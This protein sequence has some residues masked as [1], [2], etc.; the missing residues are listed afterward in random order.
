MDWIMEVSDD[1]GVLQSDMCVHYSELV[2]HTKTNV[3][4]L[5][6]SQSFWTSFKFFFVCFLKQFT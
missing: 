1:K 3:S 5:F 6:N 4:P 2:S